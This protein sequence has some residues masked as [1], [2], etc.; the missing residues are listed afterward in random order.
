[1]VGLTVNTAVCK[2]TG[3]QM[4][5]LCTS[6]ITDGELW[7]TLVIH[8]WWCSRFLMGTIRWPSSSFLFS[9][10]EGIMAMLQSSV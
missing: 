3:A 7:L 6:L 5:M 2:A 1:M 4:L 8:S 10:S 9:L